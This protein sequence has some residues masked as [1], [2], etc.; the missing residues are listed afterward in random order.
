MS[1]TYTTP[2][3]YLSFVCEEPVFIA[4]RDLRHAKGRFA[5]MGAVVA[6]L[7]TLIVL[8]TGLSAGLVD[9]NVSAL[10][11]LPADHVSFASDA[12]ISFSRSVVDERQWDALRH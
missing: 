1:T 10:V 4:L 8:L 11:A 6:L 2:R 9:D 3:R 5:L 12:G 7:T